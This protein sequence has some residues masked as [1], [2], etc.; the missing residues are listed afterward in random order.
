[1]AMNTLLSGSLKDFGLVE[2]MQVMEMGNMTGALHL[3]QDDGHAGILYF[4]QGKVANCVEF[5]AGALTLGDVLQQLHMATHPQIEHAFTQQ[6]QDVVGM[7]IGERL[8]MMR[9][10]NQNQLQ[11]ALRTKALWTARELGLWQEGKYEFIASPNIQKMLPYGETPLNLEVM[12]ITM[13]MI[14]YADEWEK[15]RPFLPLGVN[16]FLQLAPA[17]PRTTTMPAHIINLLLAVNYFRRVRRIASAVQKPELD[18]ARDVAMLVQQKL[19]IPVFN[20]VLPRSGGKRFQLP[21]PAEKLRLE[22]FE[23][24]NLL[25]R[26][27][28]AWE[29]LRTPQEQL[30][31]LVEFINWTMDALADACRANNTILDANTL[32]SILIREGLTNIGSYNFMIEQNHIDVE[33]FT[34]LCLNILQGDLK[35]AER[36]YTDASAILQRI[37]NIVFESINSRIAN[38]RERVENQEVWE[39]LF[40]QFALPH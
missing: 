39:A 40:E 21:D 9:V 27:E 11:E 29:R 3:K 7:R 30:P 1:M 14:R 33:H 10:I 23:L 20:E 13:E 28:Q 8:M 25:I 24:F 2:V 22:H 32:A 31:A 4:D 18:V 17:I 34:T 26:M 38:P 12:R 19:L 35:N 37:L 5:D 16:T 36:F 6:L 15:L